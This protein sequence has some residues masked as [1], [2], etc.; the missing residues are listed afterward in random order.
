MSYPT[1]SRGAKGADVY[2]LQNC[3]NRVGA[4]LVADGDFGR[5]TETAVRYAQDIAQLPCDGTA[6]ETLWHWLEQQPEPFPPLA[7][8]GVAFIALKET[9]GLSYYNQVTRWPHYPGLAS[10]I[11]IGVGYDLRFATSAD[12]KARWGKHLPKPVMDEIF[13]DVGKPGSKKRAGQLK[14]MGIEVPF[15]TAWKVFIEHTLPRFYRET[16]AV[17]PSLPRLPPLCAS[18][19]V[20]IVFNRGNSLNGSSRLEMRIIRDLLASAD[21]PSFHQQKRKMILADVEDQIV[22]MQRLWGPESG[23]YLRRQAEANLWRQGLEAW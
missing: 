18:A 5:G 12:V 23:L 7:T 8:D 20:S 19:L 15:K 3:L 2:H 10:G 21:N 6:D 4:M 17:Y 9:G 13:H 1:L 22:A 16:E 14:G 11:T